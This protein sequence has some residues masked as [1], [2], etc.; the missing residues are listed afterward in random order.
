M[1]KTNILSDEEKLKKAVTSGGE[2]PRHIAFIM[3]G[4]G[5]WAHKRGLP[6]IVGHRQGVKTV[7][8]MVE[9]GPE[10][11]V[12]VMTFYTFSSENWHRPRLEVTALMTLLLETINKELEDLQRNEVSLKII[13]DLNALPDAPRKA[14]ERAIRETEGNK[15][16]TL[17]LAISYS[18]RLEIV[19][20]VNRIIASGIKNVD[21]NTFASYLETADLPD[22]E[23]L[24]RTS[25]EF[26]LSNFLLY[27]IAYS[28]I[29][30]TEK[31]W[32]DFSRSD[33]FECIA[34]YQQRERRFGK[35]SE[36]LARSSEF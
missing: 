33:L 11:G 32:P 18:G 14:L 24:I 26:R 34:S 9:I 27:Q 31:F 29:I 23:L 13:G 21:E 25:G 1:V 19:R 20:A 22:P 12:K 30:V 6:R 7:R 4:N 2:I 8:A 3:D 35:T 15:R 28:E 5:R 36:Q 16:L 17:V 10:I